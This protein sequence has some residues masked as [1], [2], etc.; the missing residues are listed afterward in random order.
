M[1]QTFNDLVVKGGLAHGIVPDNQPGK[2]SNLLPVALLGK[3]YCKVDSAC[4]PVDTGDLLTTSPTDGYD[5]KAGDSTRS[6]GSVLYK[7]LRLLCKGKNPI[8]D[9]VAPQ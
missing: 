8:P 7:A 1:V 3:I 5:M 4:T 2:Q 9:L 6:F